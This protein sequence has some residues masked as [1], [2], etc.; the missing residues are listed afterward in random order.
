MRRTVVTR[1]PVQI[2][3]GLIISSGFLSS[4][5]TG[6]HIGLY[7]QYES[8]RWVYF[9]HV[10]ASLIILILLLFHL[11]FARTRQ[12]TNIRENKTKNYL[13]VTLRHKM[14]WLSIFL[15]PFYCLVI[16]LIYLFEE[17]PHSDPQNN[18]AAVLPYEY[19]YG[20]LPFL[21]SQAKTRSNTFVEKKKIGNSQRCYSCHQQLTDEWRSSMHGRSASDPAFQK[22]L[23]SLITK[24]GTPAA[25]YCS[26]CHI[27]VALL[28]GT[29][30]TGA[31]FSSGDYI[32]EGV[33]CMGCHGI[34]D[35][36]HLKGA[37]SYVYESE[38]DYLFASSSNPVLQSLHEYLININP[39]QHRKDMAPDILANPKNCATCHEQFIDKDLNDW[40][41]I[42]LQQQYLSW[43]NGP[44]SKQ[45]QQRFSH[46]KSKRCQDCHFPLVKSQDPSADSE[47][48]IR[49]HRTPAANTVIPWLLGD[50]EQLDIVKQFLKDDRIRV[51]IHV[52]SKDKLQTG[53]LLKI[54]VTV[55][56]RQIG[57]NF[58]AGTID[59]NEPWL[60][61]KVVDA[62]GHTIFESGAINKQG[63][64]DPQA[65]FYTSV[66]I[67]KFGRHVWKHDLF[68]AI[69][70]TH[71][72][73]V[74]PGGSD[75]HE[76]KFNISKGSVSPLTISTRLRYRKLN[77][78]Y[79]RWALGEK[80]LQMPIVDMA[81]D[82][83][84]VSFKAL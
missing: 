59:L 35:S 12:S 63:Q 30:S 79:A 16:Y 73:K 72:G 44:F 33:S 25:R 47:G 80:A 3:F 20:N 23:H 52:P 22:N 58:P 4:I 26:G 18:V 17:K 31:D 41:W 64:V 68:N 37:A 54:S 67:N 81:E 75:I 40:G 55:D 66:L 42:K 28:S 27:P 36:V 5:L 38:Q 32:D 50:T 1:K 60:H 69:G 43:L 70:E 71:L 6:V 53:K 34:R 21:P 51:S 2:I 24:K 76:Y 7:G 11:F 83:V 15:V 48:L 49:S 65:K 82:E 19:P 29:V 61:F 74:L 56:S 77:D 39:R 13:T 78:K 84:K 9:L 62:A 46:E 14:L 8:L 10:Y 57:H 45:S